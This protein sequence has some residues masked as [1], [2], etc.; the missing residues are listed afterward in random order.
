M[1]NFESYSLIH[2]CLRLDVAIPIHYATM[3]EIPFMLFLP[4]LQ[5]SDFGFARAMSAKTVV[6]RS[7]KGIYVSSSHDS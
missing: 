6:S 4:Y 3:V 1:I 2:C 7:I 5:L